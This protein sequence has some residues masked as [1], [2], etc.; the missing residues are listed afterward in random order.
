[1]G[2]SKIDS[3][4]RSMET[5]ALRRMAEVEDRMATELRAILNEVRTP[6]HPVCIFPHSMVFILRETRNQ[7]PHFRVF[8]SWRPRPRKFWST[9]P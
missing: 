7:R 4:S 3:K 1:M 6:P 5:L 2:L 9:R 8:D